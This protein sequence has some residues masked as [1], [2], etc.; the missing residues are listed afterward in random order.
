MVCGSES[1]SESSR[2]DFLVPADV[3]SGRGWVVVS[4]SVISI[5][6]GHHW[7]A[8]GRLDVCVAVSESFPLFDYSGSHR[9][10]G[11]LI[12]HWD[13]EV[14]TFVA[15]DVSVVSVGGKAGN[16]SVPPF[17]HVHSCWAHEDPMVWHLGTVMSV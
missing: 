1:E 13:W 6:L 4:P 16:H 10:F 7:G 12:C 17:S 15:L 9:S 2:S 3:S 14:S 5:L 8:S 11:T